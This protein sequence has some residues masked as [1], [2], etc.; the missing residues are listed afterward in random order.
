MKEETYQNILEEAKSDSD[1]LGFILSG[2]RG[3]GLATEHSDYDT[4][5][6]VP[7]GKER[8]YQEK[9]K[10]FTDTNDVY[11]KVFSLREFRKYAEFGS[12][13]EWDRYNFSHLT[14]QA[15][16][17]GEIQKMID[18]KGKLPED[19]IKETVSFNLGCYI[20]SYHRTIKNHR[21]GNFDASQFDAA[22]SIPLLL[23]AL[24]ALEGRMRPYNKF[25][26][27]ELRNY[28]LAKLPWDGKTFFGMIKKILTGDIET[29]KEIFNKVKQLF[30]ENGFKAEI[31]DWSNYY[32]G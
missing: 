32:M 3:K 9:Y 20:N 24:F 1:I 14:A 31:D 2:G 18:E 30:Y 29:Q 16:K 6:V 19:K 5:M 11:I 27:W 28:P 23:T 13:F 21:D 7:D 15:D 12:G 17:T 4:M 25:L 8:E 22:E 26:E 10:N